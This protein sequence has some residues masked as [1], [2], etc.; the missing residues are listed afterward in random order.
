MRILI[1]DN[2]LGA[3]NALRATLTSFGHCVLAAQ[4]GPQ[5]LKIIS[6][7]KEEIAPVELMVTDLKMPG[8]S[9]LEFIE[10]VRD[11]SPDL[12]IILMTAYGDSELLRKAE[13]LGWFQY[14][15]KPTGPAKLLQL[16]D[17]LKEK[18]HSGCACKTVL[19]SYDCV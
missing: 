16:I 18:V 5:A 19:Y 7:S 17:K 15:S 6:S 9:G 4:D 8:I 1:V 11:I 12:P 3:L 14:V 13:D 2:D 10:A